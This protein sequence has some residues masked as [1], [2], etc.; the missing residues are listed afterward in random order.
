[1]HG[2]GRSPAEG[3]GN[4]LQYSC[5]EN[6]MDSGAWRATV[7]RVAKSRTQIE[8]TEHEHGCSILRPDGVIKSS[9]SLYIDAK[10]NPRDRVLGEVEKN[11]SVTSPGKGRHTRLLPWKTMCLNSR[12]FGEGFYNRASKVGFLTRLEWE[13]GLHSRISGVTL[14]TLMSF[15][16]P[17]N[18]VSG[19]FLTAPPLNLPFGTQ[20][21]SWKLESC[22]WEMGDR[23]APTGPCSI[24]VFILGTHRLGLL[25]SSS[26][27]PFTSIL[28]WCWRV[29]LASL[30]LST[31]AL[32]KAELFPSSVHESES[33]PPL[34]PLTPEPLRDLSNSPETEIDFAQEGFLEEFIFI[35]CSLSWE[36]AQQNWF[37]CCWSTDDSFGA[38]KPDFL[39]YWCLLFLYRDSQYQ[40]WS[41]SYG[42]WC[43]FL[44]SWTLS[45][46][47]RCPSKYSAG[48]ATYL[49]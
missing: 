24:S 36:T 18:L 41:S 26:Q 33:L 17:F 5:L 35:V 39:P 7:Q 10:S 34:P 40:I 9:A 21:R 28:C 32:H 27:T 37:S 2:G 22:L 3:N 6:A 31:S 1:M 11:S 23:K 8:V 4:P 43:V 16:V 20:G 13:Q 45:I 12:E 44:Q 25:G 49:F 14:L 15:S 30:L 29:H 47:E 19:D 46:P 42:D 48:E 38:L